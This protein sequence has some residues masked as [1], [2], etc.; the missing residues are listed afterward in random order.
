MHWL[1]IFSLEELEEIFFIENRFRV[2]FTGS[3]T[4]TDGFGVGGFSVGAGSR[5]RRGSTGKAS[6]SC[7]HLR[8]TFLRAPFGEAER[9][10][11]DD[12]DRGEK[13][14]KEVVFER[15]KGG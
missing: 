1:R 7:L 13:L 14:A 5:S 10:W 9:H 8:R 12:K 2:K 3:R 4:G 15:P 6:D 11:R